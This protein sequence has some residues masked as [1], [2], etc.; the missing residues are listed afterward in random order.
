MST[1]MVRIT[2]NLLMYICAAYQRICSE[3]RAFKKVYMCRYNENTS[4]KSNK[5]F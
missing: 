1:N 4:R 3:S 2:I 5:D